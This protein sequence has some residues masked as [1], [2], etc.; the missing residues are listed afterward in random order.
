MFSG[1]HDQMLPPTYVSTPLWKSHM[2]SYIKDSLLG[3]GGCRVVVGMT[4][5]A[6]LGLKKFDQTNEMG[7]D[8]NE[9]LLEL[10]AEGVEEGWGSRG[11]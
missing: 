4:L 8:M 2:R 10:Q 1:F 7:R 3:G 6:V 5:T 11:R 9:R